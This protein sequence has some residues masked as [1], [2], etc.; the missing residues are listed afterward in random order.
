MTPPWL[1]RAGLG[2]G[3]ALLKKRLKGKGKELVGEARK[4]AIAKLAK[5]LKLQR[6]GDVKK[7]AK[8]V[9]VKGAIISVPTT[10]GVGVGHIHGRIKGQEIERK[11]Q[12]SKKLKKL[13][14]ESMRLE[15]QLKQHKKKLETEAGTRET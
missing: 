3:A 9:A 15:E 12:R 7:L 8:D 11:K 13:D 5:M 2:V 10:A 14:E 6:K 4:K 1:A